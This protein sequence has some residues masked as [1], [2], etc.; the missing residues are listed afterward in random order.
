MNED[1]LFSSI[2]EGYE[3]LSF[4]QLLKKAKE[5]LEELFLF[6]NDKNEDFES[7]TSVEKLLDKFDNWLCSEDNG[8]E[9]IVS[10]C[11]CIKELASNAYR[12][13]RISM[14]GFNLK[15]FCK[16]ILKTVSSLSTD[17]KTVTKCLKIFLIGAEFVRMIDD[18]YA[19]WKKSAN[20]V[21]YYAGVGAQVLGLK[22]GNYGRRIWN[23][24]RKV[25]LS[26]TI[27]A[28][29]EL[30]WSFWSSAKGELTTTFS[31][32]HKNCIAMASYAYKEIPY[33]TKEVTP[34]QIKGVLG[35]P[36]KTYDSK[37]A[38]FGFESWLKEIG[39]SILV[40]KEKD[41]IFLAFSGTHKWNI[42]NWITNLVQYYSSIDSVYLAAFGI[43]L[44]L[45]RSYPSHRIII[46]GH[47]LGGGL[48]QFTTA[49]MC[50]NNVSGICYNSAGLSEESCKIV[51]K[52]AKE[53][54]FKGNDNITHIVMEHDPVS[55]LGCL[56][57]KK[58]VLNSN[59]KG[60]NAHDKLSINM[61]LNRNKAK[62][63]KI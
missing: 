61:I 10:F 55:R 22:W 62:Y 35:C 20:D 63:C 56:L 19:Y 3:D 30:S 15:N 41:T 46:T 21:Y 50:E 43:A 36:I 51:Q 52:H 57:G 47:S 54:Q 60:L 29:V 2:F 59:E 25:S 33:P 44:E 58:L 40:T 53:V 16:F 12:V 13:I 48:A 49:S 17:L 5:E 37:T 8:K 1:L 34:L 6:G 4:E 31:P 42:C 18:L 9:R 38:L 7:R 27:N 39:G 28:L 24:Y 23:L 11:G 45:R 14:K 32:L 26:E